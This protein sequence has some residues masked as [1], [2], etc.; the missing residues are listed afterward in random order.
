MSLKMIKLI[1]L[2][3]D[4]LGL[5]KVLESYERKSMKIVHVAAE[6]FPYAKTGGL[7]DM[8][9]SL[10]NTLADNGH[11]VSVFIPGY[12]VVF[13][14]PDTQLL[15]SLMVLNDGGE[16]R[17]FS[18]RKNLTVLLVCNNGLFDRS[19]IY[20]VDGHDF[21]DNKKRYVFF[22]KGVLEAMR[23]LKIYADIVHCHDWQ[24]A[25]LPMLLRDAEMR[26][27]VMLAKKTIFTI[28]NIAFQGQFPIQS[29]NH[30]NL[31]DKALGTCEFETNGPINMLKC[32]ILFADQVTTV[33]PQ[34]ALEIQ[35]PKF[36]C[37]LEGVLSMRVGKLVGLLNGIDMALWNP[38]TD[39]HLPAN[40][41]SDDLIGKDVCRRKL[42]KRFSFDPEFKGPVFG[43]VCRLTEQKGIELVLENKDFFFGES[44]LIIIGSGEKYYEDALQQL[45]EVAPDKI[46]FC[47]CFDESLSHLIEAGS[48]FFLMPSLFEPC[49]LNQMY[50]QVYG[51][52]PL[53]SQVGGLLDTV[54]D[55]DQ[56]ADNGTGITFLPNASDFRLGLDRA[57]KLYADKSKLSAVM[58]RGMKKNFSWANAVVDYEEL[59]Q[60][61]LESISPNQRYLRSFKQTDS[62][63]AIAG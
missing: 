51:T 54:I 12:K 44:R 27:E 7:A 37:G 14:H 2:W 53:V 35:T 3:T 49:G 48:D 45:M 1:L 52:V 31:Y 29:F 16:I 47:N 18:P 56:H 46:S 9:G 41:S 43:M 40:Y 20:G 24:T 63:L 59:Y 5:S 26:Y 34:Y 33:S 11:E 39:N 60:N 32:G 15:T 28:H 4:I 61:S 22:I 19:G 55:I 23:L 58:Q 42:L 13:N 25:L 17:M 62:V 36:G 8:V 6:Y 21:D 10:A 38:G 57:L 50:S 30:M